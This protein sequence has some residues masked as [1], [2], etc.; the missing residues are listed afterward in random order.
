M[1]IGLF[2]VRIRVM[3]A[4]VT[5]HP[6]TGDWK[7]SWKQHKSDARDAIHAS[8]YRPGHSRK[9]WDHRGLPAQHGR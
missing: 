9:A 4:R 6:N 2:R 8:R 5:D 7:R 1:L 3:K